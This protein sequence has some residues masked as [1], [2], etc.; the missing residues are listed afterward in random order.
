MIGQSRR[1]LLALLLC[2]VSA[3]AWSQT[4]TAVSGDPFDW[5]THNLGGAAC[6]VYK[7]GPSPQRLEQVEENT[8]VQFDGCRMLLQ[9][10]TIDGEHSQVQTFDVR[11]AGLDARAV[12]VHEWSALPP[13]WATVGDLPTH[14]ITLTVPDGQAPVES[15]VETFTGLKPTTVQTRTVDILVRHQESAQR[16]A[17]ALRLAVESC[18]ASRR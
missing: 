16:I 11:L 3:P 12:T 7:A 2:A 17:Q 15:Q 1:L 5:L 10:A 4:T 8:E 9:R 13:E 6:I 14:T 18:R